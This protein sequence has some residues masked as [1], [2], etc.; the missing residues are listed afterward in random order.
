MKLI[1]ALFC[2]LASPAIAAVSSNAQMSN[3]QYSFTDLDP[4][5]GISSSLAFGD[6]FGVVGGVPISHAQ[7]IADNVFSVQNGT[8]AFSAVSAGLSSATTQGAASV[9]G[10]GFSNLGLSAS[11]STDGGHFYSRAGAPWQARLDFDGPV[12]HAGT[13]FT[14]SAFTAVT[15]SALS[16]I[17]GSGGW[18]FARLY[19]EGDVAQLGGDV[20]VNAASDTL[21]VSF[22]N[23]SGQDVTGW[24]YAMVSATGFGNTAP[25]PEPSTYALMLAGLA[26]VW[27]AARSSRRSIRAARV[28]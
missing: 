8:S 13:P 27:F 23:T 21:R 19:T 26:G 9:S 28:G 15:F 25:I 18:A 12:P 5:D 2:L 6:G 10:S 3:F 24:F 7:V 1:T 11:G 20:A 4:N 14:L 22:A 16:S 17:G